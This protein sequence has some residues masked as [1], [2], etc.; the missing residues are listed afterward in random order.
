[1]KQS[2]AAF[3]EAPGRKLS[4]VKVYTRA[5]CLKNFQLFSNPIYPPFEADVLLRVALE[6]R[7]TRSTVG[8]VSHLVPK[9]L[10]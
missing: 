3:R 8:A 2:V 10:S 7:G 9:E 4:E 6:R 1:M 5:G